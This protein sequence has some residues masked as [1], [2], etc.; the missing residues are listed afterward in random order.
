MT[1]WRRHSDERGPNK[2]EPSIWRRVEGLIGRESK[3]HV[4]YPM[5]VLH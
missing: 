2:S 3:G 5:S 1:P 4:M